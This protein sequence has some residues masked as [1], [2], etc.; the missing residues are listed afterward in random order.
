MNDHIYGR[1]EFCGE[2]KSISVRLRASTVAVSAGTR[3]H[4]SLYRI[5][6]LTLS[7]GEK[8]YRSTSSLA[9][10][11]NF[12]APRHW[13]GGGLSKESFFSSFEERFVAFKSVIF[14]REN[15]DHLPKFGGSNLQIAGHRLQSLF[16][17]YRKY[18]KHS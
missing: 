13:C 2:H 6:G 14:L 7:P 15:G 17:Q 11:H 8:W 9:D 1:D 16:H 18:P 5:Y 10:Q 3:N 12:D 4:F